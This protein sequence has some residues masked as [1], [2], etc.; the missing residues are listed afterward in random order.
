[1]APVFFA[2]L[3]PNAGAQVSPEAP[4]EPIIK[5]GDSA[6]TRGD[7]VAARNSFERAWQLA[8]QAPDDAVVRYTV[9]K[10]LSAAHAA[11]RNF[12]MAARYLLDSVHWRES[13]IGPNDPKI[14]G[15][16]TI[17]VN[18]YLDMKDF[19]Q[20]LLTAQ[21]IQ[22]MHVKAHSQESLLVAD[23]LV[24]IAQVYLVEG[25][26]KDALRPLST[27][28]GIRT[29]LAGPL[30]PGLL[31]V[32]DRINE[33]IGAVTGRGG[34]E[35]VYKQALAIRESMYGT[36]SA[37]LITTLDG[38]AYSYLQGGEYVAAEGHYQ[39]LVALWEKLAGRDDPRVA[40]VLEE[41]VV[42]YSKWNRTAEAR[43]TLARSVAIRANFS[44]PG[45]AIRPR[46]PHRTIGETR[47]SSSMNGRSPCLRHT[48]RQ[49]GN[50]SQ[51]S[52][53]RSWISI[54]R[55]PAV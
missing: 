17:L 2:S 44:P 18:L 20:A 35:R 14:A 11:S 4:V 37:Q 54:H 3:C 30:D 34:T 48:V 46:T 55:G 6:F 27:A 41:L 42:L 28:Y 23:D 5:E 38:L 43:K 49:M 36:E 47:Q 7:Y 1:L 40:T 12:S 31:P 32:L 52:R 39:R 45:Y 24:R 22:A 8:Q 51:R 25:K 29:D 50:W 53:E 19:D 9:L 10:R 15:D 33:A 13:V 16:L 21:S 26:P